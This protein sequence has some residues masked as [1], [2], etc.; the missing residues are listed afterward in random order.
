MADEIAATSN[1]TGMSEAGGDHATFFD[2]A[3][4]ESMAEG[5]LTALDRRADF[6]AVRDVAVQRARGFT[7]RR[8]AEITL[9][10]YRRVAR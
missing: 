4:I 5:I 6:E 7:W 1:T 3:E 9:E 8:A 10:T 2:P